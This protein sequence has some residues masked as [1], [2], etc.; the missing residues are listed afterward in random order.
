MTKA[1]LPTE[2]QFWNL[3]CNFEILLLYV[4]PVPRQLEGG[5]LSVS[6]CYSALKK[7]KLTFIA[8]KHK[9]IHSS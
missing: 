8:L 6:A 2:I 4:G 1:P 5:L 7:K 3:D 9:A